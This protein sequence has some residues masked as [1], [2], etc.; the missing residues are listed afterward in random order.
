MGGRLPKGMPTKGS[1]RFLNSESSGLSPMTA[2]TCVASDSQQAQ[3]G[4]RLIQDHYSLVSLKEAD[5][6]VALGGDGF[7][8]HMLHTYMD[9]GLPIYGMNRGTVGF[10]M[11]AFAVEDL[12]ERIAAAQQDMLY[13]LRMKTRTATGDEEEATAF[14][15]VSLIRYS[16]QSANIE[17][18]VNGRVGIENLMCDGLLVSTAAGS[19]AY[20]FSAGGPIIPIGVNVLALTPVSAFRPRKWPGAL[21]PNTAVLEFKNLDSKKRPLGAAADG[22]EVTDVAWVQVTEDREYPVNVLF[23]PGHSLKDRIFSEQFAY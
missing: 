23:D 15:E 19:T 16:A 8:L 20:N 22:Y 4:Y 17:V 14:N 10:L 21:I 2:I 6:L 7:L 9:A 5:V 13:P 11:N 3:E 18:K 12:P 1:L